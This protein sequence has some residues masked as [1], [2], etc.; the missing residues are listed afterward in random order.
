MESLIENIKNQKRYYKNKDGSFKLENGE[1]IEKPPL[2]DK[3]LKAYENNFKKIAGDNSLENL[4][5]LNDT[6][7][8]VKKLDGLAKTTKH[9]I[10]NAIIVI[11]QANAP[12]LKSLNEYIQ[13]RDILYGNYKKENEDG[14][15]SKK[16]EEAFIEKDEWDKLI[17]DVEKDFKTKSRLTT[18]TQEEKKRL[19][20]NVLILKLYNELPVRNEFA[21]L[22]KIS[23]EDFK[24][25]PKKERTKNYLVVF[26][27][28]MDLYL[29]DYK[30]GKTYGEKQFKMS[31]PLYRLFKIWFKDYNDTNNVF[32][33]Q[34]NEQL[35]SN[36]LTKLLNRISQ[37]Y[38]KKNIS[39][40]MIRKI[41]MSDKY[42]EKNEEQKKDANILGHSVNTMN[43]VYVKK[44]PE[45]KTIKVKKSDLESD[46]K[47]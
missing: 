10:L 44:K 33:Q 45:F 47:T 12:E 5:W 36:N 34:N 41:L 1:K 18:T 35:T 3:T 27:T 24:K 38:L 14:V 40:T 43:N 42:S 37:K 17:K 22:I 32:I 2:S 6:K 26:K 4:E 9:N 15:I 39:T 19:F 28:K 21:S 46:I 8:I 25:I 23:N 20:Q 29:N 11:I 7:P 30:T 16:Q 13:L 31:T